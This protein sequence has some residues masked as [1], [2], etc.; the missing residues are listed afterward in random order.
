[1]IVNDIAVKT[2]IPH[3]PGE[4][5]ILKK[6]S[7]K[8]AQEAANVSSDVSFEMMKKIGGDILSALRSFA[9]EQEDASSAKLD[10]ETVLRYGISKWSYDAHVTVENIRSLDIK[11]ADWAYTEILKLNE[12]ET[13]AER[14]ND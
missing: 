13:E 3:E 12:P 6:L 8:Q 7:W 14:K 1:M 5:M 11:T 2:D 9:Q 10:K 4:W